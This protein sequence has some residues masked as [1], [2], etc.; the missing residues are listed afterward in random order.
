M[1]H[2]LLAL[3]KIHLGTADHPALLQAPLTLVW[4]TQALDIGLRP[5]IYIPLWASTRK[6]TWNHMEPVYGLSPTD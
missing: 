4:T 2:S 3:S 6:R 5:A 1:C